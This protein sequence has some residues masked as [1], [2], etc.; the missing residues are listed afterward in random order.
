ME[1][2]AFKDKTCPCGVTFTPNSGRQ[3]YHSTDCPARPKTS[4]T[5]AKA[6]RSAA[7]AHGPAAPSRNGT[8]GNGH[9]TPDLLGRLLADCDRE[10]G[11]LDAKASPIAAALREK[12]EELEAIKAERAEVERCRAALASV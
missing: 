4:R 5:A 3:A 6:A 11:D 7:T 2:P 8:T 10:L 9:A 12:A 1:A